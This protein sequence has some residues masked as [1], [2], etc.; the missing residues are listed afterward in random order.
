M[1]TTYTRS[2]STDFGGSIKLKQFHEEVVANGGIAPNITGVTMTGDVIEIIFD[3][4]LSA[5]EETTLNGLINVHTADTSKPKENFYTETAQRPETQTSS[6]S[7][8]IRFNYPGSDN[9]GLIDYVEVISSMDSNV[10]SYNIRLYDK[11]NDMVMA[12]L[13]GLTNTADVANDLGTITNIPTSKAILEIHV[14]KNG[15][16]G[17]S[18][19]YVDNATIYHGN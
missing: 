11:T 16:R 9:A 5:G 18:K 10:T 7:R 1:S 2:L 12:E 19:V 15:G 8:V 3:A 4:A 6:Y 13:T 14:K 17:N